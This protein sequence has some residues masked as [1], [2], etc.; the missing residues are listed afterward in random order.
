MGGARVDFSSGLT[1]QLPNISGESGTSD[2]TF[3][4]FTWY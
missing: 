1:T 3:T 2:Q 4:V